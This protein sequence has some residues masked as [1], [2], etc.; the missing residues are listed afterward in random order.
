MNLIVLKEF[1]QSFIGY[2]FAPAETGPGRYLMRMIFACHYLIW[3]IFFLL[4]LPSGLIA[5]STVRN[6]YSIHIGSFKEHQRATDEVEKLRKIELDAFYQLETITGKGGFY[7]VYINKYEDR[8][9]AEIDAV[10][11]K[12]Q[13]ILSYYA[14]RALNGKVDKAK[15]EVDAVQKNPTSAEKSVE[16]EKRES[17]LKE[18]DN[19]V[20]ET[21]EPLLVIKNIILQREGEKS[22]AVLIHGDQ[23]FWPAVLFSNQPEDPG[24]TIVI[25]N[26]SGI[27][28]NGSTGADS[29][30]W[31]RKIRTRL[32]RD[33]KILKIQLDLKPSTTFR[34][35]QYFDKTQ[36]IYRLEVTA[37]NGFSP[38]NPSQTA[39]GGRDKTDNMK[40][41]YRQ[42]DLSAGPLSTNE[43]G[44]RGQGPKRQEDFSIASAHSDI[45]ALLEFWRKAWANKQIDDYITC[46][47]Q[48]FNSEDKDLAAWKQHKQKIFKNLRRIAVE[49]SNLKVKVE[50]L[51][52]RVYFRQRYIA[53]FYHDDGYKVMELKNVNGSWRITGEKWF[54]EKPN[55]WPL[56]S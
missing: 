4:I 54:A 49:W 7:R 41:V 26:V 6:F 39:D 44:G 37:G 30:D 35:L 47:H 5:G 36:N 33:K 53:D 24:V 52:A 51:D 43:N 38:R 19:A 14:I 12:R 42:Q 13:N 55:I 27:E 29:G 3:S 11:M 17:I 40:I 25:K 9:K 46:Y 16:N 21:K 18:N 2:F 20:N 1:M 15:F 8:A 56:S 50:N 34:A 10:Q 32:D 22:G 28:Q 31:V 48:A 23:H 45:M